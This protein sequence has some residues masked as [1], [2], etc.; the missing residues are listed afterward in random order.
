MPR[1][2]R[3]DVGKES[4]TEFTCDRCKAVYREEQSREESTTPHGA[5]WG[6]F[7]WTS[8]RGVFGSGIL[9]NACYESLREFWTKVGG[10]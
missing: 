4:Y 3:R 5:D 10:R 9:C 7:N 8:P 6:I 2:R 1:I